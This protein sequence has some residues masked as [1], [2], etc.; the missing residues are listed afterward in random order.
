MTQI[1]S[2]ENYLT[3]PWANGGGVTAQV[4]ASPPGSDMN[5]FDWRVSIAQ[6]V[7]GGPFSELTGVDRVLALIDGD[8]LQ[9]T[10]DDTPHC[11]T[12]ESPID[13]AG[14]AHVECHLPDGPTRDLNLMTRRGRCSGGMQFVT[15]AVV[16][17]E[18]LAGDSTLVVITRGCFFYYDVRLTATDALVVDQHTTLSGNG[19]VAVLR[20]TPTTTSINEPAMEGRSGARTSKVV[21]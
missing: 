18:P 12:P 4:A 13:F 21:D 2:A 14:E 15:D 1:L 9:L 16:E 20:I 17:I 7:H 10:I 8:S 19:T 5:S 6:I 11:L 3:M